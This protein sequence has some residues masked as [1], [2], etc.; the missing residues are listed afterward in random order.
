MEKYKVGVIGNG[1]VGES[2]AFA[3]SPTSDLRIYDIDPLKSTHTKEELD[4][5]D[6]IFVCVP[7]PMK[8]DGSQ[9]IS[10]IE[11]VFKEAVEG[12]IYIIKSTILPGST[13]K[14]QNKYP[15]LSILF[16]P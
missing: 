14:L 4:Q 16:S 9:D 8:K 3:F 13:K 7:T 5:C 10:F 1:F 12:P 6:F 15:K 2:Q 11:K